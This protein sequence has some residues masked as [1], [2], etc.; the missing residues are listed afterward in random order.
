[1]THVMTH[2]RIFLNLFSNNIIMDTQEQIII[3]AIQRRESC[4]VCHSRIENGGSS[5]RVICT[6]LIASRGAITNPLVLQK[7]YIRCSVICCEACEGLM[8]CQRISAHSRHHT[9]MPFRD[10]IQIIA[11]NRAADEKCDVVTFP[12]ISD[13]ELISSI[14]ESEIIERMTILIAQMQREGKDQICSIL[15]SLFSLIDAYFNDRGLTAGVVNPRTSDAIR[16][17]SPFEPGTENARIFD[18]GLTVFGVFDRSRQTGGQ[19]LRQIGDQG[20]RQTLFERAIIEQVV[21]QM[22]KVAQPTNEQIIRNSRESGIIFP[23]QIRHGTGDQKTYVQLG[24]FESSY[25]L[26]D[27]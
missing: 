25:V 3:D 9:T 2:D 24:A 11:E 1:M 12:S 23:V 13:T 27:E 7:N 17:E 21:R 10:A 16:F 14:I 20:S 19:G 8:A 18:R 26:T 5:P 6:A 15:N 4:P 22:H